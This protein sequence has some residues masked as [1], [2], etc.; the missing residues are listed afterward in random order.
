MAGAR[1]AASISTTVGVAFATLLVMGGI[2]AG[3]AIVDCSSDSRG[4]GSC[5][6]DRMANSGLFSPDTERLDR[7]SALPSEPEIPVSEQPVVT[8]DPPPQPA[9]W[10]EANA[11]ELTSESPAAADLTAPAGTLDAAA[12]PT[13]PGG[14]WADIALAPGQGTLAANGEVGTTTTLTANV[15]AVPAMG[16]IGA[17]GSIGA[18]SAI[19]AAELAPAVPVP[20]PEVPAFEQPLVE[21]VVETPP[22]PAPEPVTPVA[23]APPPVISFDPNYP[24]V[25][26]LP[27]PASGEDLS[28]RALQLN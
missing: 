12:L 6:R 21:A 3:P 20:E 10:L 7:P 28:F 9:G 27:P 13:M 5:I 22:P 16:E 11:T 14:T 25:L 24:N 15:A 17:T 4:F 1:A 8:I 26:V 18:D 2:L 19:G 23:E